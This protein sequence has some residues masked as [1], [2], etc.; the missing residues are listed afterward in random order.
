MR[1]TGMTE[2]KTFI[3]NQPFLFVIRDRENDMILFMG[4]IQNLGE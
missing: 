3:A 1:S 2:Q 4:S